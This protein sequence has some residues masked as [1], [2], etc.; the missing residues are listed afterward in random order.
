[1]NGQHLGA[2]RLKSIFLAGLLSAAPSFV[3]GVRGQA[4]P[5]FGKDIVPILQRSCQDCHRPG[6]IAPMS[7]LT[8]DEVRPWA[9]SIKQQVTSRQMPP[10]HASGEIGTF[11]D[12]LRL[13]D[14]EIATIDAWIEQGCRRGDPAD[15][16]PP[17]HWE[18]EWKIGT[19]DL[20]L[21]FP[22]SYLVRADRE[23]VYVAID[24]QYQFP[25]D[26]WIKAIEFRPGN[27]KRVHH[28]NVY[29]I[30]GDVPLGPEGMMEGR[31]LLK[32]HYAFFG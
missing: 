9:K 8:Y 29:M 11:L 15:M 17:R 7:L 16:P 14:V 31:R 5:T 1:M 24:M 19:P 25:E 23:E 3:L 32:G 2:S 30:A 12:D 27:S 10:F 18:S 22:E 4:A 26:T 6:Q 13:S 21:T 20:V 28:A